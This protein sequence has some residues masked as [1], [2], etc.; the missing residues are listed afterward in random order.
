MILFDRQSLKP[1]VASRGG[2]IGPLPNPFWATCGEQADQVGCWYVSWCPSASAP[3]NKPGN[4]F[5]WLSEA[6]QA[7]CKYSCLI[8]WTLI[9]IILLLYSETF[10]LHCETL[11]HW[12]SQHDIIIIIIMIDNVAVSG[13]ACGAFL[14]VLKK[15][16][17]NFAILSHCRQKTV[18]KHT[19]TAWKKP[20]NYVR[21][22]TI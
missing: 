9:I 21:T 7:N 3:R 6:P 16:N 19:V 14:L 5:K 12:L 17:R 1:W 20:I 18:Q 4:Q 22:S 2:C 11:V 10:S 13:L 8:A 15:R